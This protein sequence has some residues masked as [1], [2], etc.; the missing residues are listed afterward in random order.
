MTSPKRI[1]VITPCFNEQDNVRDCYEAVRR[2]F[3]EKL[4]EYTYEHIFAD[5]ASTDETLAVLKDL[6]SDPA[7]KVIVNARNFG[8]FRSTFNAL[9]SAG[10]DAVI[11]LMAADLQDPPEMIAS[12]VRKWEEG[13]EVVY[14]IRAKREESALLRG[15]RKLYYRTVT[16]LA[17]ISI[18][19]D[20]GEFQLIDKKVVAALRRFDDYYP[21]IR[22]MIASC[23]FRATGIKYD[24]KARRRGLSKNR[25]YNLV[26]QGLN[27]IISFT[28][29]PLRLC[30]LF[31]LL[32]A[33]MSFLYGALT[34]VVNLVYLRQLAEP[35]IPTLIVAVFFFSGLQLFFF[36]VLG[37]YVGAIHSQVRKRPLVIESARI[38]FEAA[39][40]EAGD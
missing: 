4:P 18:P 15:L 38:N 33:A 17:D 31:G 34:L 39:T 13:F 11:V 20:V 1:S 37:E 35:G 12:F 14:G 19:L 6:A 40:I 9:M 23:G 10:G 2:V 3:Q 22:G 28:N 21:Y 27:G 26:D 7:V 36:G 16:R 32:V 25:L 5:N 24:W 30:M 29:V 8:P